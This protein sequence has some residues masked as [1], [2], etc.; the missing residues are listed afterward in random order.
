MSFKEV[1][2]KIIDTELYTLPI[3]FLQTNHQNDQ[4]CRPKQFGEMIQEW[5]SY[6]G[7]RFT[8][9][10]CFYTFVQWDQGAQE[11]KKERKNLFSQKDQQDV[12]HILELET[13]V[14]LKGK[15]ENCTL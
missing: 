14:I 2:G 10:P 12:N 8:Y 1:D 3:D 4:L 11:L 5:L 7:R 13:A 6:K 9:S 15:K